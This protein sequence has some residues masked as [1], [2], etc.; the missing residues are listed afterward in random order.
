MNDD[1]VIQVLGVDH[2]LVKVP[3]NIDLARTRI[4]ECKYRPEPACCGPLIR[5]PAWEA[6]VYEARDTALSVTHCGRL[7]KCNSRVMLASFSRSY[8]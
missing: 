7:Q 3:S 2:A 5:T 8:T 1:F 4:V 6:S